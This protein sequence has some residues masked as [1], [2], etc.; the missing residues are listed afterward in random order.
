[1][2]QQTLVF[3]SPDQEGVEE[4]VTEGRAIGMCVGCLPSRLPA[5]G[6]RAATFPVYI[7]S[8]GLLQELGVHCVP[9]VVVLSPY[10]SAGGGR[11]TAGEPLS[12]SSAWRSCRSPAR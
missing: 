12:C 9:T 8:V 1:M 4:L 2:R 11:R 7:A 6:S 3:F 10:A 5:Y